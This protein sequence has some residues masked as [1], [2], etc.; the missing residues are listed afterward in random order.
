MNLDEN[1]YEL[2]DQYLEGTLPKDHPFVSRLLE[3]QE[4]AD[5]V[6]L[7]RLMQKTVVDHRLMEVGQKLAD[8]KQKFIDQNSKKWNKLYLAVPV[9]LIAIAV[10]LYVHKNDTTDTIAQNTQNQAPKTTIVAKENKPLVSPRLAGTVELKKIDKQVEVNSQENKSEPEAKTQKEETK[11]TQAIV[12]PHKPN[13][14]EAVVAQPSVKH[15]LEVK[16]E[17]ENPCKD[18]HIKAFIDSERPCKGEN[19]GQLQI[20]Q[21]KGGKAPY[22]YSIDGVHFQKTNLFLGL[23][24]GKYDISIK[25]ADGCTVLVY[26]DFSLQDKTCIQIAEHIFNPQEKVWE[27]P[28]D[29]EKHGEISIFNENGTRV[30]YHTFGISEKINWTGVDNS[31][32]LLVPNVY[33]YNIKY[34]DGVVAHGRVTITY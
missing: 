7:I 19:E 30:Y 11:E 1:T 9:S 20:K 34:S 29:P 28:S 26:K 4:L 12:E 2:I 32:V 10:Y 5:E 27:V 14:S 16:N 24:G 13:A 15:E 33:I 31:G 6:E 23:G 21:P 25:D 22:E 3:N 18:L 17:P 8:H